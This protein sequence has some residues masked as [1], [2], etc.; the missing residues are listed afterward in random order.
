M[1][2][3][4][5]ALAQVFNQ[6][7]RPIIT[8]KFYERMTGAVGATADRELA[9]P[10]PMESRFLKKPRIERR[11]AKRLRP[12]WMTKNFHRPK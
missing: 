1:Q 12:R 10:G 4:K 8:S 6:A 5:S 9:P 2:R 3:I 7:A 11:S